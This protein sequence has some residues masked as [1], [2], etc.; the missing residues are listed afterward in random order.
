[1]SFESRVRNNISP[2]QTNSGRAVKVQLLDD[3]QTV[4]AIASP[5]GRDENS[6]TASQATP[7]SVRPTQTPLPRISSRAMSSAAVM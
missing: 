2:I 5:A 4:T 6:V 1:M 3:P 7:V